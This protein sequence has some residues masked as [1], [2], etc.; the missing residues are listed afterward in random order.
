MLLIIIPAVE[1]EEWDEQNNQ[2]IYHT[3]QTSQPL[4]LEHSLISLS[5]WESKWRKSFFSKEEKSKE[6]LVDYVRFMT[7][8]KNIDSSVYDRLTEENMEDVMNYIDNPMTATTFPKSDDKSGKKRRITSELI[9]YW[10]IACGIPFECEKWHLNRLVTLIRV[11]NT[12]NAP[13][14]KLSAREAALRN[15]ERNAARK[16]QWHT[17]G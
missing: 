1:E 8:D 15:A 5:K 7:L 6:E 3:V 10:M 16:K 9:Y 2:F 13:S 4:H 17:K 14:K 11:C 12:E